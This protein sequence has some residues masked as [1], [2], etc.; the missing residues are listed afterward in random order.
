MQLT[1]TTP[2]EIVLVA[3]GQQ[4]VVTTTAATAGDLLAEQGIALSETDKTSLYLNQGLL[5]R[6]RLQ[7]YRVQ[8]NEVSETTAVPA[9]KVETPDP[10]AFEG[11]RTVTTPGVDGQQ[12]TRYR[13]TVVDGVETAREAI[14]TAVTVAPVTE[15]VAVGTKPKPAN[16]PTADGLNWAAL[17]KCES[18][19]N[20]RAVNSRGGYYG[21]YQ[22]SLS[23][24]SAVGGTGNPIDA[25]PDEQTY[26]AQLLYKKSGAGQWTCGSHL[27]D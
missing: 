20:P 11:D 2:K 4:R 3:D 23:T 13:V 1:I 24:W 6:M 8:I 18:G 5:N 9:E 7:V 22:F 27:F 14:D 25:T 12:V 16:T 21:L 19:G 17:A 26:R 15:Q 10:E